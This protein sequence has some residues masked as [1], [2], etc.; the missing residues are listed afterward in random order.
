M[1]DHKLIK[2][3]RQWLNAGLKAVG[4]LSASSVARVSGTSLVLGALGACQAP[5]PLNSP[6]PINATPP[7][8]PQ[9][10]I[11]EPKP[12]VKPP[13]GTPLRIGLALGGGAARGFAHVGVIKVLEEA[14]IKTD[15]IVGTSAGSLVGAL[16]ASGMNAVSL[17]A[18]ALALDESMLGDWSLSLRSVVRGQALQDY[19]NRL[20]AGKRIEQFPRRF[21]ATATDLYNG[22]LRL[23]V[24]GDTGLAVRASSSVPAVFEPVSFEGR[25]YV[26]GGL[27]SPIPARATRRLGC[28]VVIAVD[29]SAKPWFQATDT[30]P[31][32][33]LQTFAIMGSKLAEEELSEADI[34][35]RPTVSDLG[36]TSFEARARSMQEGE[37][38]IRAQMP[39]LLQLLKSN[40]GTGG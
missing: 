3:R 21:A 36:A 4:T 1:I 32:V 18:A 14:G 9:A 8:V 39:K 38:A 19:V 12:S 26:D 35:I 28:D 7:T 25:E 23:F 40:N 10:P 27:V 37:N 2:S 29:I 20:L 34:V 22:Q 33:L 17:R 15:W 24:S 5:S 11:A 13:Q 30:L 31:K 16:Y 6:N